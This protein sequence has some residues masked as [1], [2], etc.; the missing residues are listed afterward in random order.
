MDEIDFA[1][2]E[3]RELE[4]AIVDEGILELVGGILGLVEE[5]LG[6]VVEIPG[7]VVVVVVGVPDFT[8]RPGLPERGRGSGRGSSGPASGRS[9]VTRGLEPRCS[10]PASVTSLLRQSSAVSSAAR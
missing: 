9:L 4:D 7:I 2:E 8:R 10:E 6:V 5:I 1:E 3:I